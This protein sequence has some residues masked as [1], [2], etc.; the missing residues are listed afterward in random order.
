MTLYWSYWIYLYWQDLISMSELQS[1]LQCYMPNACNNLIEFSLGFEAQPSHQPSA[2]SPLHAFFSTSVQKHVSQLTLW[3]FFQFRQTVLHYL[4]SVMR[5]CSNPSMGCNWRQLMHCRGQRYK[6]VFVFVS[7][8]LIL[9]NLAVWRL[10][11]ILHHS[12]HLLIY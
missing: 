2:C 10:R 8:A 7:L 3:C 1:C 5:E 12:L 11:R 4:D 6:H 9:L